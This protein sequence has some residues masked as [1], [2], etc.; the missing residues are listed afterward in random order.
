MHLYLLARM[1]NVI[2]VPKAASTGPRYRVSKANLSTD[3][4][5]PPTLPDAG[6]KTSIR[7]LPVPDGLPVSE[8]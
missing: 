5:T 1:I 7:L 4:V 3:T 8:T 2:T 6:A